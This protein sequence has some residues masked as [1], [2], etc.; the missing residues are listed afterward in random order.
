ME[1]LI[2]TL[3]ISF[4]VSIIAGYIMIPILKRLKFG[5]SILE[6]GPKWH[7]NKTG[8]PTMGGI[9]FIIGIIAASLIMHTD[10]K[11]IIVLSGALTF[12]FIGF[13]DDYIK[14]VNK[15]NLGLTSGQKFFTQTLVAI[16]FV[17]ILQKNGCV[18]DDI[19][20]PF[21]NNRLDLGW[22]Y[23][24]FTVFVIV[25]MV[26][27]VNLTDGI[28]GL[29]ASITVV[30]AIFFTLA[31]MHLREDSTGIIS[32]AVAGACMGFLIFNSYPAKVFMGDTGSLFSGGILAFMATTLKLQLILIIVGAV[33]MI[34]TL[35][36]IIQ[37]ASFKLVGKRVFKM[38]PIHH[39]FEM[40]G[41]QEKYIVKVF[42]GVTLILCII[43]LIGI[44]L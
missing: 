9:I 36:V 17:L 29:A 16:I 43:A 22:F 6:I 32:A 3:L 4:I 15:R 24:P 21:L 26:N 27:S 18:N 20:F 5:Q 37:V 19:L 33:F 38:S 23:L 2:A 42:S 14:T 12:A 1:K 28:D 7:G 41:W 11:S 40:L 31:S 44:S 34:E 25:G 39:H 35:S 30:V 13:I 8:T 10:I